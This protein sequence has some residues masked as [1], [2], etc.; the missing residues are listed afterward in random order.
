MLRECG[1]VLDE[2]GVA[3]KRDHEHQPSQGAEAVSLEQV[4]Y[5]YGGP[6]SVCEISLQV[7]QGEF[8]AILGPNGSGKTT[9]CKLMIGLLTPQ[10]GRVKVNGRDVATMRV[11]ELASQIGYLYQ[12]PDS[13][14]F[15]DTVFDEIAFG[16]RNL[17][18]SREDMERLVASALETTELLGLEHA[19]PFSLTRGQRQRVAL[20]AIL[21]C[22]PG[23]IV[24]DE[25]TTGLDAPQQ[26]AMMQLLRK[27]QAQGHSVIVVTHNTEMAMRYAERLILLREGSV[28]A[29]GPTHEI[30]ADN[31]A[32]KAAGQYIPETVAI[33][34]ALFGSVLLSA[35]EF[36]EYVRLS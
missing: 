2:A 8:V 21:A 18:R 5:S 1:A 22:E 17:E 15:A 10:H 3:L 16:P 4:S 7:Q 23:I 27:F 20:A 12:N 31:A 13:Q 26:E 14:I 28:V 32:M 30:V 25:P 36:A 9:L 6:A 33:S 34:Y 35:Q 24:F 11:A 19:D 29:D